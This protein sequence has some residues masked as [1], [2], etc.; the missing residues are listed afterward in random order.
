[1]FGVSAFYLLL[2]LGPTTPFA[3]LATAPP[4]GRGP[5]PLLQNHPLMAAHPPFLY[6]GFIGFT[7]PFAFAIAALITGRGQRRMDPRSRAGGRSPPG[8]S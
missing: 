4:D 3:T 7:V 6:L 5:L 2:V 1:M 8:S